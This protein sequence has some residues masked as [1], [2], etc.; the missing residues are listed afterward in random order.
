MSSTTINPMNLLHYNPD[1]LILIC[2]ECKYAIQKRAVSSHLLRHKIYREQRQQLL[3][4]VASLDLLEPE[5]VSLPPPESP[6]VEGLPVISGYKCTQDYCGN[7]FAS[8]KRMKKHQAEVHGIRDLGGVQEVV[9]AE[10]QTFFRGTKLRYF[11]VSN[12]QD[13]ESSGTAR[14]AF[15]VRDGDETW[16]GN[17]RAAK[18][19]TDVPASKRSERIDLETTK[20]LKQ[21]NVV[22][23]ANFRYFHHYTTT[24]CHTLPGPQGDSIFWPGTVVEHA[25]KH[26]WLMCGLLAISAS[27]LAMSADTS[28]DKEVHGQSS[29]RFHTGFLRGSAEFE[30]SQTP[31]DEQLNML[32]VVRRIECILCCITWSSTARDE[33]HASQEPVFSLRFLITTL[34]NLTHLDSD[35]TSHRN[36]ISQDAVFDM[37]KRVLEAGSGSPWSCKNAT[38]KKLLDRLRVFPEQLSRAFGRPDNVHDVLTTLFATAALVGSCECS[39]RS[40][41]A[42]ATWQ[43]A[44]GG[45][46]MITEHFES[47]LANSNPAALVLVCYWGVL[48]K[49]AEWCGVWFLQGIAGRILRKTEEQLVK[50]RSELRSLVLDLLDG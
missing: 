3:S 13:N 39:G 18:Q 43:S 37:A 2:L 22:D 47:M 31:S 24:T 1:H 28:T 4:Y 19:R 35:P 12:T 42:E 21:A 40:D 30:S 15:D 46:V 23:L 34:R 9:R 49:R 25:L 8:L 48:I 14:S 26:E 33:N 38:C 27:H 7:L 11:E 10:L 5:D 6:P 44:V 16:A 45:L 50:D 29:A 36:T 17:G 32:W 41:T 20:C